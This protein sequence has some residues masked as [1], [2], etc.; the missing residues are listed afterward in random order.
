MDLSAVV[1]AEAGVDAVAGGDFERVFA[2]QWREQ[3]VEVLAGEDGPGGGIGVA[4]LV[5]VAEGV[6]ALCSFLGVVVVEVLSLA[7]KEG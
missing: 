6:D 3:V 1:C 7:M 2:L 4:D 5:E